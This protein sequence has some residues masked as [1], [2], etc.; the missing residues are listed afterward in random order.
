M[1]RHQKK[2]KG[3]ERRLDLVPNWVATYSGKPNDIVRK[4]RA[5]FHIDWECAIEELEEIGV[6]LDDEYLSCLRQTISEQFQDEKKHRS[7]KS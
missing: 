2:F 7:I 3:R 4:Y 5:T 1:K 6:K